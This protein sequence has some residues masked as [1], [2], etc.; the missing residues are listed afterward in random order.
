MTDLLRFEK[1]ALHR[2]GRLLFEE[3]S[4][5]LRAGQGLQVTG[6]N[7]SGKSS[8]LR[9][10]AG[11]LRAAQGHVERAQAALADDHLALDRELPL[12]HALGFWGGTPDQPMAAMGLTALGNVPVRLLSAGQ[13][14]RATLAR[15][16]A[17]GAPLWLLDE[18]LNALDADGRDQ[19]SDLI[20]RHRSGGGAV[21]TASHQPLPGEWTRL[22]LGQ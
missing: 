17:S 1:V 13:G 11:L 9:L 2:G 8:L 20:A 21:V 10:A 3:M 7:G 4:F 12:K 22:E 15:V 6:A 18:P 14:K 16:A 5:A 19:L